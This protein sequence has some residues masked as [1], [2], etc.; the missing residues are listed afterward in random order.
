ML[1]VLLNKDGSVNITNGEKIQAVRQRTS[2]EARDCCSLG[3]RSKGQLSQ[4]AVEE[5]KA[6]ML[7]F[8]SV[9][10]VEKSVDCPP[11][12]PQYLCS[13]P[14]LPPTTT[15]FAPSSLAIVI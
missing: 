12:V 7:T 13:T 10:M 2:R 4:R 15:V 1:F 8:T 9:S 6:R 5:F 14:R 3:G 11:T